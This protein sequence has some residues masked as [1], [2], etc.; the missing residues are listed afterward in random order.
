[1]K[2]YEGLKFVNILKNMRDTRDMIIIRDMFN[3]INLSFIE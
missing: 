3:S 2:Y 1:M